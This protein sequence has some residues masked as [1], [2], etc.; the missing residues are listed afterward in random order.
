MLVGHAVEPGHEHRREGQVRVAGGIGAPELDPLCLRALRVERDPA[1]GR[2]VP[3]RV[4]EV[5]RCLVAGD[6]P[7]VRVRR[8]R[9][10]GEDRPGVREDAADVPAADVR[11]PAV[12][13][14]RVEER[15]AAVPER[16]VDVHAR[17]VVLEE[18]LRHEGRRE[19]GLIGDALDDVL[20]EHQLVGHRQQGVEAHVDLGLAGGADLVVLHLDLDAEPAPWP[21][22]SRS[23]GP[24]SGPSAGP[25]STPPCSAACTRGSGLPSLRRSSRCPRP[26]R[27]GRRRS[28]GPGRSGRRRR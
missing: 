19:P 1:R 10:E 13:R 2:A 12:A 7:L 16:L 18:R 17:A 21:G 25:G 23:A 24:G 20:V 11:Q 22:S 26:S 9:G 27:P 3:L 8:R 14:L 5:D 4:D 6:Q 15:L 28:A